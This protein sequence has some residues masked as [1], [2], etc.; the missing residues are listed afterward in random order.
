MMR[1]QSA[2][3]AMCRRAN[4]A[5]ISA[6]AIASTENCRVQVAAVT[7]SSDRPSRSACA[8]ANESASQPVA[9]LTRMSTGPS[10]CSARSKSIAGVAG[11]DRS[12]SI[13]MARPP[14][15]MIDPRTEPALLVRL[16]R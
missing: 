12:A 3:R 14:A 11:S 2:P 7:G 8:A 5:I 4:S 15:E 10:C 9:L 1:P 16:S 13:A 6:G